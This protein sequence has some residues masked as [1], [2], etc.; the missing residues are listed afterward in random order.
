MQIAP[1]DGAIKC[2]CTEDQFLMQQ[3]LLQQQHMLQQQHQLLL[4][5]QHQQVFRQ[6]VEVREQEL[7]QE[8]GQGIC[9]QQQEHRQQP[10]QQQQKGYSACGGEEG[11]LPAGPLFVEKMSLLMEQ[12]ATCGDEP[13]RRPSVA[14]R[15]DV[16]SSYAVL[17]LL[18]CTRA[19]SCM[20]L[21]LAFVCTRAC[22][23]MT[24]T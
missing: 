15:F 22:V 16:S 19:C 8:Q 11:V 13:C 5:H 1:Q 2:G 10:Q 7:Q 6:Q 23:H 12:L 17:P 3:E 21:R 24:C 14:T 18:L 4:Q 9:K 20:A